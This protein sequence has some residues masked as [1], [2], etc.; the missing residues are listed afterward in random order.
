MSRQGGIREGEEGD[1]RTIRRG[2]MLRTVWPG[3]ELLSFV[4]SRDFA[5]AV[6]S[7]FLCTMVLAVS[8]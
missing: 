6:S 2:W 5:F 3:R 4:M 8:L 7:D 1:V